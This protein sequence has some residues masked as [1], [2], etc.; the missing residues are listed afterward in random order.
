MEAQMIVLKDCPLYLKMTYFEKLLFSMGYIWHKKYT[1]SRMIVF[2]KGSPL[3]KLLMMHPVLKSDL[4]EAEV[5]IT[6][7]LC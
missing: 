5:M 6:S 3:Q 4:F 7:Y 2:N 1:K